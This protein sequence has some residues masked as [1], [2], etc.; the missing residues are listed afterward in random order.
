MIKN[1]ILIHTDDNIAVAIADIKAGE[2]VDVSGHLISIKEDIPKK[3]KFTTRDIKKDDHVVMYGVIVGKTNQD[4][5][6]GGLISTK[7]TY[8]ATAPVNEQRSSMEWDT[9]DVSGFLDRTF[10][11][12]HR[13]D[14]KVGTLNLWLVVPLVFCENRNIDIMKSSLLRPLGFADDHDHTIDI[15]PLIDHYQGGVSDDSILG[16]DLNHHIT[17]GKKK[18]FKNV[19]GIKFLK[20]D[21]GCGNTPNDTEGLLNLLSGYVNNPNVGGATILSLGCQHAQ[22]DLFRQRL[23]EN[24]PRIDKPLYFL[25]QQAIASERQFMEEA[26]KKTF[27]GLIEINRCIRKPA[28]IRHLT[29]GLECGGS[30]GFSGISAN[31]TLGYAAD[32]LVA[33]GGSTI[34]AEFP[35]LCGVEQELMNRCVNDGLAEKFIHLMRTYEDQARK[36]G[37]GFHNNPS[38][39][40]IMDG[41]ITD[42]MKSAG[43]AKKG[44]TSPVV[45]VLDYG[46]PQ[47]RNGLNLLCTPG[48]DVH[49]TTGLAGSGANIIAFTTGLGTPTGNPICPVVKIS[50][51]NDLFFRMND[52]IDF[53]AGGIVTGAETIQQKGKELLN[54]LIDVASGKKTTASMDLGQDDFIPWKRGVNL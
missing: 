1:N 19:D 3:H 16:I 39:G 34:L 22:V 36:A 23:K 51:N 30:D 33:S 52:I 38:P 45:D 48:S 18:V 2:T 8:H 21:G 46:E 20:H 14:G 28:P 41:L 17:S 47:T 43:A 4:I 9:P 15:A 26:V 42:A 25:E 32:L 5:P 31:P 54:Y 13:A 10:E 24:N 7:N 40:N 53:N 6:A 44:G 11:G 27:K 49:S 29:L 35:E 37:S 50:T 12:Y